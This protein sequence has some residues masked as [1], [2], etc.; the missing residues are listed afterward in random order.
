[1]AA[2]PDDARLPPFETD[3]LLGNLP[4][5][6]YRCDPVP[7]WKMYYVSQGVRELCGYEPEDLLSGRISWDMITH[8]EDLAK[9]D[10]ALAQ[11][12]AEGRAF[13]VIYRIVHKNG[14]V[15]WVHERGEAV[16][17]TDDAPQLLVGFIMSVT[18]QDLAAGNGGSSTMIAD[19]AALRR[20]VEA[21]TL[22]QSGQ[23][24]MSGLAAALA[25]ELNQP[26]TAISMYS[27]SLR[28]LIE[29]EPK[30]LE[31]LESIKSNA[32]R[33][34]DI[35]QRLRHFVETGRPKFEAVNCRELINEAL[36]FSSIGCRGVTV[37]CDLVPHPVAYADRVQIQQVMVNLIRNACDAVRGR[38]DPRV[39]ISTSV[40]GD[41]I[42]VV[43]VTVADNG[44]GVPED[45]LEHI[46][47]SG[48]ST[49]EG[50]MGIGLAISRTI[51]E[52]HG[53]RMWAEPAEIGARI[54]FELPV[55][56]P[57][58]A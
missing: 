20:S 35:I 27:A 12:V 21:E 16:R 56:P 39:V 42:K 40:R 34:G 45:L 44:P 49:K 23:S 26:L 13:D 41:A 19:E 15:R 18:V 50:G 37:T 54:R 32:L 1:M 24:A 14:A 46:F 57:R 4:G 8:A 10:A 55:N 53:G 43:Q 31:I 6:A 22:Y 58:A 51:V 36:T 9:V 17:G 47:D 11:A 5:L 30:A 52:A 2:E 28:R 29:G 25:H 3:L 48:V 38:P 7:P 33:A